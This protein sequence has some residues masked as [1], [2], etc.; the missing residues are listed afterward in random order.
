M[1]VCEKRILP[2]YGVPFYH[3]AVF[4]SIVFYVF[5]RFFPGFFIAHLY[6]KCP[7]V[8]NGRAFIAYGLQLGITVAVD[9][10]V[11][12]FTLL[13]EGTLVGTPYTVAV[14]VLGIENG[15]NGIA[16]AVLFRCEN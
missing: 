6:T 9:K 1:E 3:M 4:M 12:L 8:M 10:S 2:Q 13:A 14:K 16:D 7:S 15:M 11:E 5:V